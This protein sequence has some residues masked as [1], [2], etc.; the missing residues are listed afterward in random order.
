MWREANMTR[1]LFRATISKGLAVLTVTLTAA[2]VLAPG[3]WAASKYKILY[4]FTGGADG[5]TPYAG[6]TLDSSGNLYGTTSAGGASGDGTIFKLTKNSDGSWTESVLY[7]FAGG[8]DGVTPWAGVTFDARGNLYGTTQYGGASSVGTVFKLTPNS[9]GTWAES[10]LYSFTGGSDGAN[11]FY[12]VIFDATGA[13][14]SATSAGGSQSMGVVYKLTPNSDGSWTYG[15]LHSFTGGQDASYPLYG[16]KLTF[17]TAGNLY[18]ATSDGVDAQGNCPSGN[19]CGSIFELTPQSD[20]SWKE[21][22]IFRFQ[23]GQGAPGRKPL[24]PVMFDSAGHLYG[25]SGGGG[26]WYGGVFRLTLGAKGTWTKDVL[27]AFKGNQDG[28][29]PNSGVVSDTAGNLYGTT[30]LGEDLDGACCFGQ[31]F[32]L[33]PHSHGWSKQTLHR[34]QGSPRDGS[35][36]G[37]PVVLDTVGNLYGTTNDGGAHSAGVVFEFTP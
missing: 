33:I 15:A 25:N 11:P 30:A 23:G 27:H 9:D 2:L 24:S 6:L 22:V 37:F 31:V 35:N 18:G 34:F 12:G 21:Q 26:S 5:S 29:Y 20:G 13:L 17:D 4:N 36:S 28:A 14:Y 32:K 1:K 16:G 3:A 7:S 10:V 8:T 19:D